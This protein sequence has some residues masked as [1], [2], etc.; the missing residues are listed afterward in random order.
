MKG[1]MKFGRAKHH[2]YTGETPN[3]VAICG[4]YTLYDEEPIFENPPSKKKCKLCLRK[5][6]EFKS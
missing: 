3:F 1:W 6:E 2:Y 5:L 4:M